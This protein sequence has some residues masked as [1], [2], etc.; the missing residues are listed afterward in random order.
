MDVRFGPADV[1]PPAQQIR[2][3]ADRGG[4]RSGRDVGRRRELRHQGGGLLTQ[5]ETER[6]DR[7]AGRGFQLRDYR[8]GGRHLGFRVGHIQTADKPALEP[9]AGQPGAV[10]LGGE[11]LPGD[12][13]ALL[14]S[15]QLDV[16]ARHFRRQGYQNVAAILHGGLQ[17]GIGGLDVAANAAEDVQLPAGVEAGVVR[18]GDDAAGF[19]L[20]PIV[21]SSWRPAAL[22]GAPG[23]HGGAEAAGG[24]PTC[25][26]RLADARFGLQ[27]VQVGADGPFLE[28]GQGRVVEHRPP[29]RKVIGWMFCRGGIRS[30]DPVDGNRRLR[31]LEIRSDQASTQYG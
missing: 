26:T 20:L 21:G 27:Q 11:V 5:Q 15:A 25:G 18:V 12:L 29:A 2:W 1:R 6:V 16:V 13:D 30:L 14:K 19:A 23:V 17:V 7:L 8:G 22:E 9:L 10:L 28:C 24:D 31:R 3:Q 4:G